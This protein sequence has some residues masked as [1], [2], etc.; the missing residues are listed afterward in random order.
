MMMMLI[1]R[2][3]SLNEQIGRV[4]LTRGEGETGRC[5]HRSKKCCLARPVKGTADLERLTSTVQDLSECGWYYGCV[6][7]KQAITLLQSAPIGH[8]IVRDSS[9]PRFLFS[10]SVQTA[11]GPT[12]V[13][14]HY[15]DGRFRLDAEPS[16]AC[17]VPSFPSVISLVEHYVSL[18][19]PQLCISGAKYSH[20]LLRKPLYKN[21]PSL[22]HLC[23]LTLNT[24]LR[25]SKDVGPLPIP[26]ILKK[27]LIDY[28]YTR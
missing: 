17:S 25:S 26:I 14:I 6:S 8:F 9:D 19:G 4:I 12:S 11:L 15:S 13:R 2:S 10:I 21:C 18:G 20:V 7:R 24:L 22:K 5:R 3:S 28:P 27:Y 16:L 23:R 1:D